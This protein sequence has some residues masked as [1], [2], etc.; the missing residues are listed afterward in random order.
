MNICPCGIARADCE[1]HREVPVFSR[2]FYYWLFGRQA[3][4]VLAE[5][6]KL[7]AQIAKVHEAEAEDA[8]P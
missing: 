6:Q 8:E 7:A 4:E 1:Y 2:D 3:P 5:I